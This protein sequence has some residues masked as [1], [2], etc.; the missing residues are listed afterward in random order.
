MNTVQIP[1]L[2]QGKYKM[3]L[4]YLNT[5]MQRNA[6]KMTGISKVYRSQIEKA[7][8]GQIWDHLSNNVNNDSN[9]LWHNE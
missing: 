5:R 3:N 7:Y 1:G 9:V 2:E 8:P 4:E 6:Q